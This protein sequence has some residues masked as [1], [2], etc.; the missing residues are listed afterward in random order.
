MLS[1]GQKLGWK[2]AECA[3]SREGPRSECDGNTK[4]AEPKGELS[5]KICKQI[6]EIPV[7][8][9]LKSLVNYEPGKPEY[10]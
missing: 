2:R 4:I 6:P 8:K 7:Y 5:V 3:I 1:R 10:I 9:E